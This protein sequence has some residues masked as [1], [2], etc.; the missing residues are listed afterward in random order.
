VHD[1][2]PV[3]TPCDRSS[4][5]TEESFGSHVPYS[6]AVG[7]LMYIMTGKRPDIAFAMSR[8]VRAMDR[9]TEAEWVDVKR[10]LK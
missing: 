6:E 8:A 7:C 1:A 5:G 4:G 10:I 9:P 3:A 2:N